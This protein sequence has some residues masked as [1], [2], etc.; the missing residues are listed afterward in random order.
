MIKHIFWSI[1]NIFQIESM[2]KLNK[3]TKKVDLNQLK[4]Q[5][6]SILITKVNIS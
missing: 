1:F 5:K 3:I 2:L 4:D 6:W